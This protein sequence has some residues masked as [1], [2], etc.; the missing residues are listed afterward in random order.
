VKITKINRIK[1]HM[2]AY[3][4]LTKKN[5]FKVDDN[6]T[7]IALMQ[8][9][10][11]INYLPIITEVDNEFGFDILELIDD[12]YYEE[13]KNT[14]F[15]LIEPEHLVEEYGASPDEIDEYFIPVN[16]GEYYTDRI[17][18]VLKVA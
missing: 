4:L 18:D 8:D 1:N 17:A 11:G 15:D 12:I 2:L 10:G 9:C 7:I 16:G 6:L 3:E 5:G 14:P 13:G